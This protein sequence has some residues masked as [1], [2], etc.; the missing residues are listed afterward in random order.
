MVKKWIG[1]IKRVD[2]FVIAVIVLLC[3]VTGC[4]SGEENVDLQEWKKKTSTTVA[5]Q[6][7]QDAAGNEI[8]F[9]CGKTIYYEDAEVTKLGILNRQA[10]ASVIDLDQMTEE[11]MCMVGQWPAMQCQREDRAYLCWTISPEYSC[12]IEYDAAVVAEADIF[13]MAES[14]VQQQ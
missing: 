8:I 1:K 3:G 6:T 11:K 12:V 13:R 5:S 9:Y 14:V 4:S 7:Y 2:Y 10:L